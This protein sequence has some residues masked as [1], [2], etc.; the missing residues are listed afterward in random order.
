MS[1]KERNEIARLERLND[2]LERSLRRCRD[3]L[4]DYQV[5]LAANSNEPSTPAGDR[6]SKGS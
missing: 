3:M 1:D 6:D 4:H 5:R 2:D